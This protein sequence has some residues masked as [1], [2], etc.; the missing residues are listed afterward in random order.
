MKNLLLILSLLLF[1][2]VCC[3]KPNDRYGCQFWHPIISSIN[4]HQKEYRA[5][6]NSIINRLSNRTWFEDSLFDFRR[7][8]YVV[9]TYGFFGPDCNM[10][11]DGNEYVF[12]NELPDTSGKEMNVIYLRSI[13][14][15]D[16]ALIFAFKHPK[17]EWNIVFGFRYSRCWPSREP[18]ILRE[19]DILE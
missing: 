8:N 17:S 14:F 9:D 11:I 5:N 19:L 7:V 2:N 3:P 18:F 12:L 1:S 13:C 15:K 4:K 6:Y 10:L 16:D